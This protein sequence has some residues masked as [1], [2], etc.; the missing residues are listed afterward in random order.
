MNVIQFNRPGPRAPHPLFR[1]LSSLVGIRPGDY[2]EQVTPTK[3]RLTVDVSEAGDRT[4]RLDQ[5]GNVLT[6]KA[7]RWG[8][9]QI[10][11]RI[12]LSPAIRPVKHHR[13]G[14]VIEI[15]LAFARDSDPP[16]NSPATAP[17]PSGRNPPGQATASA[18]APIAA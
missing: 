13:R 1:V 14:D 2:V 5:T 4:V 17:I 18:P 15:D 11:R 8:A 12:Q 3:A 10:L 6:V 9:E 16:P 7:K